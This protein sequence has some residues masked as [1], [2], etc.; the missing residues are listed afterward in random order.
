MLKK[1]PR[2][3]MTYFEQIHHDNQCRFPRWTIY[4]SLNDYPG[5]YVA[6]MFFLKPHVEQTSMQIVGNSLPEVY[7]QLPRGLY[8]MDR[9][10]KDH[11][12]IMGFWM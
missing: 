11:P 5:K 1:Q 6:C 4:N 12:S 10:S 3:S 2:E 8:W 9:G 7:A